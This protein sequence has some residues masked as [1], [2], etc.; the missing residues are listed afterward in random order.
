MDYK[1]VYRPFRGR[2]VKYRCP[3][4]KERLRSPL[5]EAGSTRLCPICSGTMV[6]PGTIELREE[7]VA[8]RKRLREIEE[9]KIKGL[10]STSQQA[11]A[12]PRG[13]DLVWYRQMSCHSCGYRWKSRRNTP[14][15]KCAKCGGRNIVPVMQP[16]MAWWQLEAQGCLVMFLAA[17]MIAASITAFTIYCTRI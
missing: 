2:I 6:V 17:L 8:Q 12:K 16:R 9:E 10:S 15:A 3:G 1:V 5:K 14:P 13:P 4:C 11:K 7:E